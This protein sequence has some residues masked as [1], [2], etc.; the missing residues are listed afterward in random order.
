MKV[1]V[2]APNF[3]ADASLLEFIE[4][5]LSKLEQFYDK[6]VYADVFLKVQKTSE[7]ENKIT[8]VMLSVPGSDLICKKESKTF[9]AAI[10]ECVQS[11]GRQLKKRKQKQRAHA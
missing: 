10:D 7:K 8:E 5:R 3:A 11:L 9:E 2:Q 6:I 4:K 1:N